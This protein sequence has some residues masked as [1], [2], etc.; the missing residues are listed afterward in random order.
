MMRA[1]EVQLVEGNVSE[2][3]L[4]RI[5][6]GMEDST[7]FNMVN[8]NL[9]LVGRYV[10]AFMTDGQGNTTGFIEGRVEYIDFTG[11]PPLLIVGNEAIHLG[12][13][14][15]VA[16]GPMIMGRTIGIFDNDAITNGT[17][18]GVH[19]S[20]ENNAYLVVNG[21]N[22]RI[23][24]INFVSEA[25]RLRDSNLQVAHGTTRG[26]ISDVFVRDGEVWIRINDGTGPSDAIRF[27]EFAGANAA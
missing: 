21:T 6:Q 8:Q 1:S 16:D 9:A 27:S 19:I 17:I 14:V 13:V 2:E 23:D 15:S 10:Q 11:N 4:R 3:M 20:A 24:R 26:T 25:I 7:A 22:R 12:Q 5:L 18:A